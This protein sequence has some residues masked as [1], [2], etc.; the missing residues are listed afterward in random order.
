M[1]VRRL[2]A[3]LTGQA[4]SHTETPLLPDNVV[5][6]AGARGADARR[7]GPAGYRQPDLHAVEGFRPGC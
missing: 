3:R 1:S 7:F 6:E 4:A 2:S 5:P